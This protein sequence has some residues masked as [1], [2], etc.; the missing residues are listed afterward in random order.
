M[1][2]L[3]CANSSRARLIFGLRPAPAH[4]D[5]RSIE[6]G[7]SRVGGA[8]FAGLYLSPLDTMRA[9]DAPS[10]R[11]D[12]LEQ[13]RSFY[14]LLGTS[15]GGGRKRYDRVCGKMLSIYSLAL[16]LSFG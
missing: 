1:C 11:S 7:G 5:S 2:L 13:V 16:F 3:F 12:P 14:V 15:V 8:S 10:K 9:S 6:K 4:H